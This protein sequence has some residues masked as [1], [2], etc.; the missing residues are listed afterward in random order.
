MT[1]RIHLFAL[2]WALVTLVGISLAPAEEQPI[3]WNQVSGADPEALSRS[4]RTRVERLLRSEF[5]YF[6]CSRPI[7]RCLAERRPNRTARRLAGYVVRQ[8]LAGRTDAEVREGIRQR[9]LSAHP[10]DRA[11]IDLGQAACVGPAQAPVTVVEYS[12]F[13]CPFCRVVAPILHG[14]QER[15]PQQVRLCFKHFP[16]RGHDRALPAAIASAAAGRQGRFWP[17]H[18]ALYRLAPRLEDDQLERAARQA[19]VP[20]LNRWRQD[21]RDGTLRQ[22]VEADKLEGLRNG[23][24]GTPAIFIN[25][26]EYL[27]TKNEVELRDRIEEELDIV[28]G[29]A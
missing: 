26:K 4:Q 1:E 18:S 7:A 12:D 14:L 5:C 25:G 8:V 27:G 23:V 10:V 2:T 22:Q 3:R 15:M 24:R 16:V 11:T 28:R 9:G 21:L 29:Q 20:N 6:G 19:A 17:M 13:E